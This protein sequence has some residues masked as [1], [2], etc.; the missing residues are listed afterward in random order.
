VTSTAV[1]HGHHARDSELTGDPQSRLGG[2]R[3][4]VRVEARCRRNDLLAYAVTLGGLDDRPR[5]RLAR[6]AAGNQNGQPPDEVN[7]LLG[8]Q[9]V[10]EWST[11]L[12]N[13]ERHQGEPVGHVLGRAD[14]AS[15]KAPRLYELTK[16]VA[17][18]QRFGRSSR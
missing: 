11:A 14:D 12:S 17:P 5:A 9:P 15:S 13:I 2:H 1:L 18:E 6:G 16:C 8:Q 7:L 10:D 4:K 3:R